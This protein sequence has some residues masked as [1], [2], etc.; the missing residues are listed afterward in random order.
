MITTWYV[1]LLTQI[2]FGLA[3]E[4]NGAHPQGGKQQN[5]PLGGV[6]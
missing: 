2:P 4:V 3:Q 6:V 5:F 1:E